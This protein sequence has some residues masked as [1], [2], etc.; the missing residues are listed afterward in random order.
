MFFPSPSMGNM[1]KDVP[2]NFPMNIIGLAQTSLEILEDSDILIFT[3]VLI[4]PK[5]LLPSV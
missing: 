2:N 5:A 1:V 4:T 3:V